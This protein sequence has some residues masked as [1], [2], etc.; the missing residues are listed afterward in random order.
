M[1][2]Q[3]HQHDEH[4]TH[5]QHDAGTTGAGEL[6][7]IADAL[8]ELR[9]ADYA[10]VRAWDEAR[11]ALR[12]GFERAD[13]AYLVKIQAKLA[14]VGL[15]GAYCRA[16]HLSERTARERIQKAEGRYTKRVAAEPAVPSLPEV[17]EGGDGAQLAELAEPPD[18][19]RNRL[20]AE[21][22]VAE[23]RVS[24]LERQH[25]LDTHELAAA[26][27]ALQRVRAGRPAGTS[28]ADERLSD[29]AKRMQE[30]EARIRR[31]KAQQARQQARQQAERFVPW[32]QW[33]A[34]QAEQAAHQQ[35]AHQQAAQPTQSVE[36]MDEA[37]AKWRAS[38]AERAPWTVNPLAR[39]PQGR[40]A[41]WVTPIPAGTSPFDVLEQQ[42]AR[43]SPYDLVREWRE[44]GRKLSAAEVVFSSEYHQRAYV[45]QMS[46]LE[47]KNMANE[48][49]QDRDSAVRIVAVMD[50]V[51][52]TLRDGAPPVVDA[53]DDSRTERR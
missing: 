49:R 18:V 40:E 33:K 47:R 16:R 15:F 38:E 14:P 31:R 52:R 20:R 3:T 13:G 29:L 35:A 26:V 1:T 48:V 43:R 23:R 17:A 37:L 32:E 39:L 10:D 12:D 19:E 8:P 5:N 9:A 11:L 41:H 53:D 21:R 42:Q 51:E 28:P 2:D 24:E 4:E 27:A 46:E 50:R 30:T 45:S 34:R 36:E 22:D 7:P 25:E 6:V 44:A